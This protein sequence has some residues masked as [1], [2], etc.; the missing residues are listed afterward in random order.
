MKV[1]IPRSCASEMIQNAVC[2]LPRSSFCVSGSKNQGSVVLAPPLT[3]NAGGD[4]AG[5]V[6]FPGLGHPKNGDGSLDS[7]Q[8]LNSAGFY[9]QALHPCITPP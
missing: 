6:P 5:T 7:F 1:Q 4:R 3:R 9:L 2:S 8:L